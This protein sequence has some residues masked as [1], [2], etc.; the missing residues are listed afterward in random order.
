MTQTISVSGSMY[1]FNY[2][3]VSDENIQR[4]LEAKQSDEDFWENLEDIHDEIIGD[5]IINGFSYKLGDP[6]PEVFV[7]SKQ[8]DV[9]CESTEPDAPDVSVA[10][11]SSYLVYEQWSKGGSVELEIEDEF[12]QDEFYLSIDSAKL[13]N[14]EVRKVLDAGYSEGDF[15]FQGS[16]PAYQDLYILKSDGT[17]I[18]L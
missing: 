7:G 10:L 16:R 4:L 9:D 13:P 1:E 6:K 17:R 8:I 3:E 5:S 15:E 12:D 11:K 2:I 18:D 14:G